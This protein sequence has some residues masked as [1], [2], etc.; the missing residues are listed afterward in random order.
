MYSYAQIAFQFGLVG[1][2]N[3]Y[4]KINREEWGKKSY[5]KKKANVTAV[6]QTVLH[7]YLYI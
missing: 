3:K 1:L 4:E 6:T 2:K 7:Q 5:K